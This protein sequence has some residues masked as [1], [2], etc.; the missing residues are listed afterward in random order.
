MVPYI[1]C[2]LVVRVVGTHA[3][4]AGMRAVLHVA[5]N[6]LGAIVS[7]VYGVGILKTW[8]VAA[9]CMDAWQAL[10]MCVMCSCQ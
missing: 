5:C 4:R 2:V 10:C 3:V 7:C 8:P 1:L 9:P 6:A